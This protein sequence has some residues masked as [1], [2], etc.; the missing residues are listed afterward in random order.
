MQGLSDVHIG[1][2]GCTGLQHAGGGCSR[3]PEG[4]VRHF[5]NGPLHASFTEPETVYQKIG[6]ANYQG[7][8]HVDHH[9]VPLILATHNPI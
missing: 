6:N 1:R 5:D 4:A 9:P 3:S 7:P 8:C 2:A